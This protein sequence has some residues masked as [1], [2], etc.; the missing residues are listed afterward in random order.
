MGTDT[1]RLV[2]HLSHLLPHRL[3]IVSAAA[4]LLE[5]EGVREGVGCW[6]MALRLP[7]APPYR[8]S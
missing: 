4:A 5:E 3:P 2:T 7:Q 1:L 6:V 8:L